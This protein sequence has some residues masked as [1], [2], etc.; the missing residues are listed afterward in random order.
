[1]VDRLALSQRS[2]SI[3]DP[4]DGVLISAEELAR[5]LNVSLRT[6]RR[7]VAARHAPAPIRLGTCVRW[8]RGEVLAWIAAGCPQQEIELSPTR[9]RRN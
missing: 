5:M 9:A 7:L 6:V 4:A 2:D 8:R 3:D 1:M